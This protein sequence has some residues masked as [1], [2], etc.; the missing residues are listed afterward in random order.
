MG[1]H[2]EEDEGEKEEPGRQTQNPHHHPQIREG[3][4][5]F[6]I[7]HWMQRRRQLSAENDTHQ[8]RELHPDW[9]QRTMCVDAGVTGGGVHECAAL[10]EN[11]DEK[12]KGRYF[13]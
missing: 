1:K 10:D 11:Y 3:T 13:W 9:Q 2:C 6:W 7:P 4:T 12:Q 5:Q 8:R